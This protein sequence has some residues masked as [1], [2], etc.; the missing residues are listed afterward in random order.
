[1]VVFIDESGIHKQT[2]HSTTAV[3]SIEIKSLQKVEEQ[4]TKILKDLHI[5][6]FH[7]ADERWLMRKQFLSHVINLDFTVTIAVFENPV[8][9]DRMLAVVFKY[10]V[11]NEKIDRIFIDG[12]KPKWYEQ[13]LKKTLRDKGL[14][15]RKLTTVR[16]ETSQ[17]GLQ[18]ADCIAG[19]AR[20]SHDHPDSKD[21]R[22]WFN[23]LKKTGKLFAQFAFE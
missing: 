20:Y 9:P 4:I 5:N 10:L 3:V 14:S 8:H 2:G 22:H 15:V 16:K 21:A 6:Y 19:L 23:Q 11:A 17:P 13:K 12:K 1:M 18:L 7:W